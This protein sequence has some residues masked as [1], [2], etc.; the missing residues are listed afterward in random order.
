MLPVVLKS[1]DPKET[2]LETGRV[3]CNGRLASHYLVRYMPRGLAEYL[4]CQTE[5]RTGNGEIQTGEMGE[6][7]MERTAVKQECTSLPL[8]VTAR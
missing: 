7:L 4:L 2:L 3:S 1:S 5:Q 8:F 6:W